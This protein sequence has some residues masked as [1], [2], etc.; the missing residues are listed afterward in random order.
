M[1]F[2]ELLRGG[3]IISVQLLIIR[4]YQTENYKAATG[5]YRLVFL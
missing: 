4:D 3:D 2:Q 5:N 1:S